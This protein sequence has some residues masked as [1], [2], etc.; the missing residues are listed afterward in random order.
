MVLLLT[1]V[2]LLLTQVLLWIVIGLV[3]WFVLLKA[4]PKAF[5][6]MLVLLLILLILAV[7]FFGGPPVPN[8]GVLDVLW[9]IISFPFSPLGLGLILVLILLSGVKLGKVIK[10]VITIALILLALGCFPLV[11]YYLAQELE[12]EAIELIGAQPALAGDARRVIVL[13]AQNTTRLQLKPRREAVPTTT[14]PADCPAGCT[15]A[16]PP[17]QQVERP[18]SAE[19]FQVISEQPIQLTEHGDRILYA[20]Q[21][22][23]E[24]ARAGTR[25]LLIVSAPARPDRKQKEGESREQISEAR[26]VQ[27]LLTRTLGVPEADIRLDHEGTSVRRSAENVRRLLTETQRVNFGEQ[28]TLVGTAINMNRAALTF[29]RV[30]NESTIVIRPTDFFTMPPP[31]HLARRVQGRDLI[32]RQLQATDLLPSV[33]ALWLSS[34]AIEEYLNAIYYF[35]RGWIRFGGASPRVLAPPAAILPLQ[36]LM[37]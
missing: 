18:V 33:D 30:F 21:L 34:Q 4:L 27:I 32:E 2:F 23:Q 13:L 7:S 26:D 20:A 24:E 6:G 31:S 16:N 22:Y 28:L 19:A 14:P 1:D 25:P 37:L 8:T 35:L 29:V 36:R 15:P 9:R 17:Q 10:N 3:T 11:A 12:M 5:L